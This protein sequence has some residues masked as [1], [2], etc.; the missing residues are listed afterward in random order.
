M[1]RTSHFESPYAPLPRHGEVVAGVLSL[2]YWSLQT[3]DTFLRFFVFLFSFLSLVH[4]YFI[5]Y[6]TNSSRLFF[7][8]LQTVLFPSKKITLSFSYFIKDL[9]NS[10]RSFFWS[11][12]TVMRPSKK[13]N[14]SNHLLIN[15][16]FY[17]GNKSSFVRDLTIDGDVETNP[18][19]ARAGHTRTISKRST[20][21]TPPSKKSVLSSPVSTSRYIV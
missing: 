18:G 2:F 7:W 13:S 3:I 9:T 6:V 19:P 5:K 15:L 1:L 12:Q 16:F 20:G 4:L 21:I 17:S 11:P 10:S 14:H 8:F